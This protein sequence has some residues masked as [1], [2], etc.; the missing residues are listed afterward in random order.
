[1][2]RRPVLLA[3]VLVLLVPASG[4]SQSAWMPPKGELFFGVTY[5]W[6][7]SDRHI[8]GPEVLSPD[9]TALEQLLGVDL[10]EQSFDDGRV[11]SQVVIVDAEIGL[12]DR[13]AV[14]GGVAFVESRWL[15][16]GLA[17]Q[18]APEI[19][20]GNWHG[21]MQDGRIGARY[22][23]VEKGPWAVTPFTSFVFPAS[24]Y[25]ILGHNVIGRGL[26]EF[27]LGT[28]AGRMLSI[29]GAMNAYIQGYYLYSFMEDPNES[30]PIDRSFAQFEFGYFHDALSFQVFATW[31][32]VHGGIE[33][34]DIGP[35]EHGELGHQFE[36]TLNSHDQASATREWRTGAAVTFHVSES[37]DLFVALNRFVWGENT[38]NARTVTFGMN[39]GIQAF[40][41]IGRNA[42][43][44]DNDGN[45]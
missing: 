15:E 13:L 4:W 10:L 29:G 34:N 14:Y 44:Q 21:A 18:A 38:H 24:D 31:Q 16:S 23:A 9:L 28:S 41:G 6:L 35:D 32:K 1:M 7:D 20:D 36:M 25:D 17:L 42:G 11:Q 40:G 30:T 39:F 19:E 27:Q 8:V 45:N 22:L 26:K 43:P 3:I 5:Q 2:Y 12:T 37:A 33:W